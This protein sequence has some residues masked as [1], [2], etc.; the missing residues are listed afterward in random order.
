MKLC[1]NDFYLI[2]VFHVDG[3]G[4]MTSVKFVVVLRNPN[5]TVRD[6]PT[7][8]LQLKFNVVNI[9][10]KDNESF[11]MSVCR[12]LSCPHFVLVFEFDDGSFDGIAMVIFDSDVKETLF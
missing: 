7:R 12:E 6:F 5:G 2:H 11:S 1:K 3:L 10:I 4:V 8:M 9:V